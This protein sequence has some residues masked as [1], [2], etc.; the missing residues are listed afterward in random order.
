MNKAVKHFLAVVLFSLA[1]GAYASSDAHPVKDVDIPQDEQTIKQGAMV[2]YNLCRM[3][4]SMKYITYRDL[5]DIGFTD[6]EI[7]NLRGDRLKSA[8]LVST[9]S[10]EMN[11]ELF[12]MVPPDLSVMAKARKHG[13]QHIY[14]L[15]TSY[16]E[17]PEGGYDNKYFPHVKMPDVFG[18]S[19]ALD[20]KEKAEIEQK[21]LEVSA[22][23]LWASDPRAQERK[24][25]GKYVILYLIILSIMFYFVMKRVWSRLDNE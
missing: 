1:G 16:Y 2:Y 17:K 19:V 18:Y 12:G 11:T 24:S 5:G 20:A 21:A 14:T 7:N 22:Y 10:D 8:K 6:K 23:L 3:C 15:M 25:L 9:T 13:A 4:H